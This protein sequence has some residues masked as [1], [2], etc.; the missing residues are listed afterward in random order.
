MVTPEMVAVTPSTKKTPKI[1]PLPLMKRFAGPKLEILRGT[2]RKTLY[3]AALEMK[4]PM[5]TLPSL[6]NSHDNLIARLG[7]LALG[8]NDQLRS[9]LGTL[10]DP[11]G[12]VVVARVADIRS[13][14]T[15]LE[16]GDVIHSVNQVPVDSISSLR[17]ALSQIKSRGTAVLQVERDGGYRWLAFDM[18]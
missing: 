8:L 5:E 14:T 18:E 16:A 17:A 4:E 15:G 9:I 3:I 11:S 12:V 2:E 10:R 6:V 13:S 1:S 7:I